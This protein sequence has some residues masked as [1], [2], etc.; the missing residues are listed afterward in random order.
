MGKEW[1]Y[2]AMLNSMAKEIEPQ[3]IVVP[4]DHWVFIIPA[5]FLFLI[6]FGKF[7][8]EKFYTKFATALGP[9][10]GIPTTWDYQSAKETVIHE[11][12][13]AKQA[14]WL[15]LGISPWLGIPLLFICFAFVFFPV[16]LAYLR[17]W[18]ELD[19]DKFMWKQLLKRKLWTDN[20]VRKSA[21][22]RGR[23]LA[24]IDYF[25]SVPE[26]Y[27]VKQ[28]NLAAELIIA[29]NKGMP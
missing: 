11:A 10:I 17:F 23:S 27:A 13:H 8:R 7:T 22:F 28:Y 20:Q 5:W 18:L 3:A 24:S 25:W 1:E 15:G 2:K 9:L 26:G 12:R 14:R 6:T 21:E 4:K 29:L 19:A 16:K